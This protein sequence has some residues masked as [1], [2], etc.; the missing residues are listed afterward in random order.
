MKTTS[1]FWIA[2]YLVFERGMLKREYVVFRLIFDED[3]LITISISS[4]PS[5]FV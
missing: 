5:P 3:I 2:P 4:P 1:I